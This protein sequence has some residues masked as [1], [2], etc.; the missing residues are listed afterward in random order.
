MYYDGKEYLD[1]FMSSF[2]RIGRN[3]EEKKGLVLPNMADMLTLKE[4]IINL[5]FPGLSGGE[6]PDELLSA[7]HFHY[8]NVVKLLADSVLLSYAY[9]DK[10]KSDSDV[11]EK[12]TKE[13]MDK[14]L[15]ALPMIRKQL[16]LDANAAL[17]GDP[18]AKSLHEVILSYPS[19][20]ALSIHRVSH[21]LYVQ[22][23]PLVPRMLNELVHQET[24]IDIH[25]GAE[26]GKSFFID[27]G[28]G[29]V[30]GETTI[31][32]DNVKLYQG[33]TLGAHSFPKNACGEIIKG[34][35]R[36]PTIEDGVTI[37]ANAT[38]LGDVRIGRNS[39][40]GSSAWINENIPPDSIVYNK[41]AEV[42]IRPIVKDC[43]H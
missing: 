27:H 18:A 11:L 8:N 30:I 42:R 17:D 25:P 16:K 3:N 36:H 10:G 24:G 32:G 4:E 34:A 29:T 22:K 26:I 31:I 15:Y 43:Q 39:I 38:I 9:E 40:I 7:I 13:S 41:R 1:A 19:L 2:E 14:L 35:K 12:K 6:Y 21:F 33:V 5:F 28:T 20:R 23:V 37:Y